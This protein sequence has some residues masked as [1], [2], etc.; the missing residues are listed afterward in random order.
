MRAC[1]DG[2]A[3]VQ[4][5]KK[6]PREY[7]PVGIFAGCMRGCGG[8]GKKDRCKDVRAPCPQTRVGG[9][10]EGVLE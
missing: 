2:W 4:A 8:V 5:E 9:V 1:V 6:R 10:R 7:M 3:K